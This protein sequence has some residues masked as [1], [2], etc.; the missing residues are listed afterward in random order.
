MLVSQIYNKNIQ[1]ISLHTTIKEVVKMMVDSGHNAFVVVDDK[2]Q[3]FGIITI[4]DIASSI[5]PEQF[6]NDNNMAEA[7]YKRGFFKQ[8]CKKVGSESVEKYV[9]KDYKT[10]SLNDNIMTIVA[11]F[12]ENG[13]YIVPIMNGTKLIG[14]VA[15]K[16]IKTVLSKG[17]ELE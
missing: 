1:P 7:M 15:R 13:I 16:E 6:K 8:L 5:I 11:N 10:A 17:L 14:I 2:Q 9:R 12:L 3:V 4:Q